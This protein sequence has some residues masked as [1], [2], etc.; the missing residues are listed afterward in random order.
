MAHNN[1]PVLQRAIRILSCE[2]CAFFIHID[3]K[4]DIDEFSHISGENIFFIAK[5]I[6]VYWGEF[7]QVRATYLLLREAMGDSREYDYFVLL[8]GSDYPLRSGKYI[9]AF[10]DDNRGLEFMSLVKVP[11][12]E[13][14]KPLS[15]INR[16]WFPSEKP[17]C[18]LAIRAL[19][20]IGLDQ[21]DYRKHLRNLEPYSGSTWWALTKDACQYIVQFTERNQYLTAYFQNTFASDEAFFHTILGNS[22]FRSHVR[23]NLHFEDWSVRGPHPTLIS[24]KHVALL[25]AQEKVCVNDVYGSGEVLFTRKLSDDRLDLLQRI[26]DMILRKE[27]Q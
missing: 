7:S 5:R 27:K 25:E 21:R 9:R 3:R 23:R 6:P 13:A 26:D 1:A 22:Q 10:L 19:G 4:S 12:E 18:R 20:K 8:S 14:G 11:N 24:D 15:R 17:V 2:D 16:L